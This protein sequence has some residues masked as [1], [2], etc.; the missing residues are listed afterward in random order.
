MSSSGNSKLIMV[1]VIYT[2]SHL[3]QQVADIKIRND[4]SEKYF[5]RKLLR[6]MKKAEVE[7]LIKISTVQHTDYDNAVQFLLERNGKYFFDEEEK[8]IKWKAK[9]ISK[10]Y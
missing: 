3:P 6:G 8:M 9:Y 2:Y 7:D 4:I 5:L 1:N 10:I